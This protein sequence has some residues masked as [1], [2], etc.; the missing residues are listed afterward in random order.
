VLLIGLLHGRHD[1]GKDRERR[2]VSLGPLCVERIAEAGGVIDDDPFTAT[3]P[4]QHAAKIGISLGKSFD[5]FST[6]AV[7][8]CAEDKCPVVE[9]AKE[10]HFEFYRLLQFP[11]ER[12]V[13]GVEDGPS[14]GGVYGRGVGRL[15]HRVD[16]GQGDDYGCK[17]REE[18]GVQKGRD[19]GDF[20][21]NPNGVK[22]NAKCEM[23]NEK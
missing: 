22:E 17:D 23:K 9:H 20:V 10:T 12:R 7:F 2:F 16:G 1:L 11:F 19:F 4:V 5:G 13:Q 14:L 21:G 3:V 18:G 15:R 6:M 8:R